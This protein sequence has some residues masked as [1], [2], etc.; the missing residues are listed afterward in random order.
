MTHCTPFLHLQYVSAE[1]HGIA[2]F[3]VQSPPPPGYPAHPHPSN[4]F[5]PGGTIP[6]RTA[7]PTT[8]QQPMAGDKCKQHIHLYCWCILYLKFLVCTLNILLTIWL[9]TSLHTGL[10]RDWQIHVHVVLHHTIHIDP[11]CMCVLSLEHTCIRLI[12]CG[13][14]SLCSLQCCG[15]H[16]LWGKEW[17]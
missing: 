5:P 12:I 9:Y 8:G 2:S 13:Y 11:T 14:L 3:P 4:T 10:K 16:F 17:C 6:N 7:V 1:S 15:W